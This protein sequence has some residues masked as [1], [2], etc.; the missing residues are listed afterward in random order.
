MHAMTGF[1]V[2]LPD[3]ARPN[4]CPA[5]N[6]PASLTPNSPTP[7]NYRRFTCGPSPV[8]VN[9][10]VLAD[11]DPSLPAPLRVGDYVNY[12]GMLDKDRDDQSY[13]ISLHGLEAQLGI[14]TSPGVDPAYVFIEE[15]LQG[16]M[17]ARWPLD[18][19]TQIP[20]EATS[21]FKLVGFTS[22]PSRTISVEIF[23]DDANVNPLNP[24]F[25]PTRLA[26]KIVPTNLAQLGRFKMMWAAKEDAR[27]V[28]RNV[29]VKLS[30]AIVGPASPSLAPGSVSNERPAAQLPAGASLRGGY[31]YGQYEA[32]IS[33][34]ISP[35]ITRFGVKGWPVPVN[36]E[37]FCFLKSTNMVGTQEP[38]GAN[39]YVIV[40]A[41]A[42]S[43]SPAARA[44]SQLRVDGTRVCGD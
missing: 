38:S 21:V 19:T 39:G 18:A 4:V 27:V 24:T 35:E 16:T 14:Y 36:F 40:T 12:V 37:D 25:A 10:P 22:D 31:A 42:I 32:P 17:G 20:Q 3:S 28:R 34:Y 11:C 15:A 41:A 8:G 1:P 43:P 2:C 13:F 6:R 9:E 26:T 33:E 29:R 23:D 7:P 44:R 30:D 5:K